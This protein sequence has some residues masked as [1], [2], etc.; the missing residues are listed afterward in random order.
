MGS[1]PMSVPEGGL[2]RGLQWRSPKGCPPSGSRKWIP[3]GGPE[4]FPQRGSPYGG[5]RVV[6]KCGQKDLRRVDLKWVPPWV[7]PKWGP[8][9]GV[10]QGMTKDVPPRGPPEGVLRKFPQIGPQRGVPQSGSSR[11]G[12]Q[13]GLRGRSSVGVPTG[14]VPHDVSKWGS[15]IGVSRGY[16]TGSPWSVTE[17][18][19]G[20]PEV[21][22]QGWSA[23]GSPAGVPHM[24]SSRGVPQV[25]SL[26]G[27]DRGGVTAGV[28][29]EAHH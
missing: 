7:V 6:P 19:Q 22:A 12:P 25:D 10:P 3:R 20:C 26:G 5:R 28:P 14:G 2:Q 16:H 1:P 4:V 9:T 21:V 23:R 17:G 11:G 24:G 15:A 13:R 18:P 29:R 27:F 8:R